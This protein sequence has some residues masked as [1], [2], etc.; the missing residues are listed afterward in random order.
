MAHGG[1]RS[2]RFG[3]YWTSAQQN[4]GPFQW[5]PL[6]DEMP[7]SPAA[8]CGRCRSSRACR[9]G[10]TP[11]HTRSRTPSAA[12]GVARLR[13]G[14]AS[15]ATARMA[16]FWA[17]HP[18]LPSRSDS[19]LAGLERAQPLLR[20]P[21]QEGKSPSV[22]A[23]PTR[24]REG[25]SLGGS[26]GDDRAWRASAPASLSRAR[27]LTTGSS[28]SSTDFGPSAGLTSSPTTLMRRATKAA[29]EQIR[30]DRCRDE[31]HHDRKRPLWLTELGWASNRPKGFRDAA[32]G[33]GPRGQA[34]IL[35]RSY[36]YLIAHRRKLHLGRV[37]WFDW[38]D[39]K[40]TP[41]P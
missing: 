16:S 6:D 37:Y 5:S 4:Q 2:V 36:K 41:C 29:K 1:I 27:S 40:R 33:K 26:V 21:R 34:R 10:S 31:E 38:I 32:L 11:T 18:N 7:P 8:G 19:G 35:R 17:E 9:A 23:A 39:G 25:D 20:G 28:T 12:P 3:F 24:H 15:A 14:S 13:Q 22:R 30:Q